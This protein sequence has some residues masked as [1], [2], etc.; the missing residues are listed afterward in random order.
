MVVFEPR[1]DE[2][3]SDAGNEGKEQ[4]CRDRTVGVVVAELG[5]VEEGAWVIMTS[6]EI[7]ID[8]GEYDMLW[9]QNLVL[10]PERGQLTCLSKQQECLPG[11]IKVGW[12]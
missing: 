8:G 4:K 1:I 7:S 3:A 5:L 10:A 12:R 9:R 6:S 11:T 2:Q